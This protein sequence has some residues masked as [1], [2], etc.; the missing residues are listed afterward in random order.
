[1]VGLSG[2]GHMGV[3]VAKAM[4][5]HVTVISSSNKKRAEAMDDQGATRTW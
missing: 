4:G 3:K 5:H 2:V 1:V